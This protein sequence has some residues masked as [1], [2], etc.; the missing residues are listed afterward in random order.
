MFEYLFYAYVS[1]IGF[2]A[3]GLLASFSQLVTGAP[4]G[5]ALEPQRQGHVLPSIVARVLAGPAIVMRNAL[6]AALRGRA[7]YW[8]AL[9]TL[10]SVLWSFFSGVL[11]LELIYR[12]SNQL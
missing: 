4:M 3:A 12:L 6:R 9:S 7:P 5:F 1:A 11:I 8:L 2:C 10:I